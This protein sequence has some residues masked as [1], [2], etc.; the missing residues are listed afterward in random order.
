MGKGYFARIAFEKTAKSDFKNQI[1]PCDKKHALL[2][3][4]CFFHKAEQT[5]IIYYFQR[6]KCLDCNTVLVFIK[7]KRQID[8]RMTMLHNYYPLS[9]I[10]ADNRMDK[11]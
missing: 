1:C 4:P 11:G 2:T 10:F 6:L 5:V 7:A 8:F 9:I 3:A